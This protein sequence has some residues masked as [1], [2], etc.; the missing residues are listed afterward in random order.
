MPGTP[1]KDKAENVAHYE[2]LNAQTINGSLHLQADHVRKA[3]EDEGVDP[4]VFDPR[5]HPV[6]HIP[7]KFSGDEELIEMLKRQD[8]IRRIETE[9]QDLEGYIE[10]LKALLSRED[11]S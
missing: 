11:A 2:L 3:L 4:P 8:E 6:L 7:S 9:N 1:E 5:P 10:A